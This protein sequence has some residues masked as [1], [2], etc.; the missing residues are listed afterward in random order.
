MFLRKIVKQHGVYVVTVPREIVR[1]L[2]IRWG[3]YVVFKVLENNQVVLSKL[4]AG[5]VPTIYRPGKV[6]ID[7]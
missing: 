7:K 5:D 2:R 3:D 6:E 4:D 1:F